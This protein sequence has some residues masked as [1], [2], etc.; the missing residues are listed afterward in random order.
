MYIFVFEYKLCLFNLDVRK[1]IFLLI[2]SEGF[3]KV[4]IQFVPGWFFCIFFCIFFFIIYFNKLVF[5]RDLAWD[6]HRLLCEWNWSLLLDVVA[7]SVITVSSN[8]L[9]DLDRILFE[10]FYGVDTLDEVILGA[11]TDVLELMI[12]LLG[13]HL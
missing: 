13:L 9:F 4:V 1:I 3:N 2:A 7:W 6:W 11:S 12:D 5:P 10:T 8:F